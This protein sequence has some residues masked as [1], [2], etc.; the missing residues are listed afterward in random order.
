MEN[1]HNLEDRVL[2]PEED[3]MLAVRCD[4]AIGK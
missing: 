1:P 2:Y 4:L 3:D